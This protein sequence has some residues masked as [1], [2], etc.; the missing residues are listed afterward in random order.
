ML[1]RLPHDELDLLVRAASC[2]R[3]NGALCQALSGLAHADSIL[4]ALYERNLFLTEIESRDRFRWYRFHPLL[5]QRLLERFQEL[6]E[7]ER[8]AVNRSACDWFS[9]HGYNDEAVRHAIYAGD[10]D[11]AANLVESCARDLIFAGE[12]RRLIEWSGSLP[13]AATDTRL[14][15]Q[16]SLA[17]AQIF[18]TRPEVTLETCRRI[19]ALI[20]PGDARSRYELQLVRGAIAVLQDD[21]DAAYASAHDAAQLPPSAGSMLTGLRANILIWALTYRGDHDGARDACLAARFSPSEEVAP[22]R[23]VIGECFHGMSLVMQGEILQAERVLRDAFTMGANLAG[24][25]SEPA[26][27]AAGFLAEPLYELGQADEVIKLVGE[28]YDLIECLSPLDIPLRGMTALARAHRLRGHRDEATSILGQLEELAVL[29]RH[30]RMLA[31]TLGE[32]V[33]WRLAD[34]DPDGAG[35]AMRR[36]AQLAEPRALEPL[37]ATSEVAL[38]AELKRV[39]IDV[40]QNR[41]REALERAERLAAQ[42]SGWRRHQLVVRLKLLAAR[43][44]LGLREVDA[45]IAALREALHIG[46]RRGLVRSFLDGGTQIRD[47]MRSRLASGAE[48]ADVLDYLSRLLAGDAEP[49]P[50]P[51]KNGARKAASVAPVELLTERELEIVG[52]LSRVLTNKKIARALGI[53]DGTVKWHMKNIYGKLGVM[54]RDEALSRCRDLGLIG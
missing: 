5:R 49:A 18:N 13:R 11:R 47:L 16:L 3:V 22:V 36:L 15:L 33:T 4:A 44:H 54:S 37:G 51:A 31:C 21:S 23:R 42:C 39:E 2:R 24:P 35:E 30:D 53:S 27:I 9:A 52:M 50:A 29:H 34:G 45:A 41:A 12:F 7:S 38:V 19:E 10:T 17:W 14:D 20:G 6:G 40:A 1:A 43:A 46:R 26:S 25:H 8:A 48:D 32:Q 28:R